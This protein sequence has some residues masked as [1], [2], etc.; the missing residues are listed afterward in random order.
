MPDGRIEP[1]QVER[2][3]EIGDWLRVNGESIYGTRGG[4]FK[5]GKWGVST[6]K[7]DR[8]YVH[9]LEWDDDKVELPASKEQI[10]SAALMDGTAV[11]FEQTP[12][13]TVLTLEKTR[14]APMDTIVVLTIAIGGA[15]K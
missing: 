13:K 12:E 8:I 9:V 1:R 14:R 6:H 3:R 15:G 4:P 10:V 7:G 2:L 11:P 5:P